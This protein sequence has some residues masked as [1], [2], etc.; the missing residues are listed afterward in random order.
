M[1]FGER[2]ARDLGTELRRIPG[3]RHFTPE[4]HPQEVARGIQD[5]VNEVREGGA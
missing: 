3:G 5:L 1:R 2:F 4:D